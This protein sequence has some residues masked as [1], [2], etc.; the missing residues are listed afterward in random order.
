MR[1]DSSNSRYNSRQFN[2]AESEAAG[3]SATPVTAARVFSCVNC[4][5]SLRFSPGVGRL[6]CSNCGTANELPAPSQDSRAHA[7]EELDYLV[8]LRRQAGNEPSIRPQLVE[9]PQCGAAT[10]LGDDVVADACAFC[11]TPLISVAA[12]EGR[13]IQ[14]RAVVPFRIERVAVQEKF[15]GW[16]KSRWLAPNALARS[17]NRTEAVRGV[18]LPCWTF[19]ARTFSNYT[20]QRGINR[21]ERYYTTDSNGKQVEATRTVT[22]WH[23]AAGSVALV[24]DD[25]LVP[26]SKS[27]PD[28]LASVLHGWDVSTLVPCE[29]DY[30]AGFTVEAYQLGLEPAF[31]QARHIFDEAI[32]DAVRQ[33]IGGDHQRVSD[34]STRYDAVTFKHILLPVWI[35]SYLFRGKAWRVV[36][37]GQTGEVKGDRPWSVWKITFLVLLLVGVAAAILY[38]KQ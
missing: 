12:H 20:G 27:I 4:G 19:D 22:D 9:C 17:V 28:K 2:S 26:A 1:P 30:L 37:N 36:V 32:I 18:Y 21:Q 13:L 7:L 34:V 24:F 33:D 14:P 3:P 35:C 5:A 11:A 15:Q 38:L 25:T 16:V 31:E 8:F 23:Y 6:V 29:D 10:Q